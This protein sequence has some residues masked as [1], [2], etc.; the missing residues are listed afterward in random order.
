MSPSPAL[1]DAAR[2]REMCAEAGAEACAE[3]LAEFAGQL[4]ERLVVP[5][6]DLAPLARWAHE[7]PRLADATLRAL[8][9]LA[10]S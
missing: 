10:L 1:L 4:R 3:V 2:L 5:E 6:G 8:D 7:I 9:A